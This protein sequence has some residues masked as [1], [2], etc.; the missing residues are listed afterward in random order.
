[1]TKPLHQNPLP[2][3]IIVTYYI[4]AN[5]LRPLSLARKTLN[6][7]VA[8]WQISSKTFILIMTDLPAMACSDVPQVSEAGEAACAE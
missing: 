5:I 6:T 3:P 2:P 4:L 8:K 7:P 1:M